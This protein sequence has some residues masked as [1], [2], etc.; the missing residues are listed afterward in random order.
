[1]KVI[2]IAMLALLMISVSAYAEDAVP[3]LIS[4]DEPVDETTAMQLKVMST[5]TG[6]EVRLLQLEKSIDRNILF[7]EK[8]LDYL[9][10]NYPDYDTAELESLLSELEMLKEDVAAQ[11]PSATEDAVQAFVDLKN[12]ARDISNEFRTLV[13][14]AAGADELAT[15]RSNIVNEISGQMNQWKNQI[16]ER[17]RAHNEDVVQKKLQSMNM[18]NQELVNKVKNGMANATEVKTQIRQMLQ[19]MTPGEK[20]TAVMAMKREMTS[21]A[22]RTQSALQ[23]AEEGFQQRLETRLQ[24]RLESMS[25]AD[26][27]MLQERMDTLGIQPKAGIPVTG[28]AVRGGNGR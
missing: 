3:T 26:S 25:E 16:R 13:H 27:T 22:V 6:A 11:D 10:E 17:I 7:G 19:Q 12:D 28:Q 21:L 15:L 8:V 18:T 9:A 4:A 5:S 23:S 1:M 24:E 20:S 14:E 2:A